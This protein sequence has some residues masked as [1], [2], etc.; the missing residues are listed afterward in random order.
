MRRCR[1]VTSRRRSRCCAGWQRCA[2]PVAQRAA[3]APDA[4]QTVGTPEAISN[5]LREAA[6]DS[7]AVWISYVNAEGRHSRR[8]VYPTLVSG[9]FVIGLDD[10]SGERRTFAISR[11]QEAAPA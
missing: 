6:A 3:P 1:K 9:G 7:S 4:S 5:L 2:A 10:E 11:I 8:T